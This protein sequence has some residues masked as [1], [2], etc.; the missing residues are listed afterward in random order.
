M[1][2]VSD[3]RFTEDGYRNLPDD[4]ADRLSWDTDLYADFVVCPFTGEKPGE[5]QFV[6][7][8]SAKNLKTRKE[9][10]ER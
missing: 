2:G 10:P 5:M 3:G 8:D 9:Q 6:C 4:I 1:L 7:V